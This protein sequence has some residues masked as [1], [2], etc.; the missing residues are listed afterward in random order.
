MTAGTGDDCSL[1]ARAGATT[2]SP[3]KQI[4]P[5][6]LI[7][8]LIASF[9]ITVQVQGECPDLNG[10]PALP[11]DCLGTYRTLGYQFPVSLAIG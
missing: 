1:C 9:P 3:N 6:V 11:G 10:Q 5:I 8:L 4:F 7:V 2:T